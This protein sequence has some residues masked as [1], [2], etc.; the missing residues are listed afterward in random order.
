MVGAPCIVPASTAASL[1]FQPRHTQLPLLSPR[2][3]RP[4]AAKP[5]TRGLRSGSPA[6]GKQL[7]NFVGAYRFNLRG[8]AAHPSPRRGAPPDP[9]WTPAAN[10]EL[11]L[12]EGLCGS[13]V[14]SFRG[15]LPGTGFWGWSGVP[16][17][18]KL[19]ARNNIQYVTLLNVKEKFWN[20]FI[21]FRRFFWIWVVSKV[22]HCLDKKIMHLFCHISIL[23][24]EIY[25]QMV[26]QETALSSSL[27]LTCRKYIH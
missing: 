14:G 20:Y 25:F 16:P 15:K 24:I 27:L 5:T 18:E 11:A 4:T 3:R 1:Y 10:R 6:T 9:P 21:L 2:E 19:V 12:R 13:C 22:L 17:F 8:A 7:W 26:L 23:V